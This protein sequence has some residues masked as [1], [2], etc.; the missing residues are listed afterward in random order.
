MFY[1]AATRIPA[2]CRHFPLFPAVLAIFPIFSSV[3]SDRRAASPYQ[4]VKQLQP[5]FTL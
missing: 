2:K 4:G 1:Q 3:L 5:F